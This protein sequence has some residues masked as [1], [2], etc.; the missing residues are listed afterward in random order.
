MQ[1]PAP[2]GRIEGRPF[3]AGIPAKKPTVCKTALG[4]PRSQLPLAFARLRVLPA[5]GAGVIPAPSFSFER[6]VEG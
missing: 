5:Y 3:S 1:A 6:A 2:A 4:M